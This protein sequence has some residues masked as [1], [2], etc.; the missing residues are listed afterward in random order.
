MLH[1]ARHGFRYCLNASDLLPLLEL[2]LVQWA[3]DRQR[4]RENDHVG[5]PGLDRLLQ[6]LCPR[7]SCTMVWHTLTYLD[8]PFFRTLDNSGLSSCTTDASGIH[9]SEIEN[10][11]CM[12]AVRNLQL[13]RLVYGLELWRT[14]LNS[15]LRKNCTARSISNRMLHSHAYFFYW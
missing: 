12:H 4:W 10:L 13:S 1:R 15:R 6:N 9:I 2:Y 7:D 14:H 3:T 8:I 5:M 11:V